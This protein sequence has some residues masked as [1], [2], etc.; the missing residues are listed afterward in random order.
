MA[1]VDILLV[2][3]NPDELGLTMSAL[4]ETG[5][6][7]EIAVARDG[8]EALDFI[9]CQGPFAHR[10]V[11]ETPRLIL[12]DIKLPKVDGIEVL[13]RIKKDERTQRIPVVMLTSS[14]R[15]ADL[16]ASYQAGANS[17]LVKSVDYDQFTRDVRQLGEYWLGLNQ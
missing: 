16:D 5:A 3:D 2:D 11:E 17:Y 9:F 14:S 4:R 10:K 1:R 12:L 6:A 13:K 7:R 15:K 8:A